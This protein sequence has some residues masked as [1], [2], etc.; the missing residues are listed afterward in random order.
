[1]NCREKK[2]FLRKCV[3]SSLQKCGKNNEVQLGRNY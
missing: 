1:M 2:V 3:N